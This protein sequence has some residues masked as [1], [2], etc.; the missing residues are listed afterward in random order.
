MGTYLKV[1]FAAAVAW[2]GQWAV[3]AIRWQDSVGVAWE[4]VA[5]AVTDVRKDT[6]GSPSVAVSVRI[7]RIWL[8]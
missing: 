3:T 8:F 1:A 4:L 7:E 2:Q 5:V 6:L